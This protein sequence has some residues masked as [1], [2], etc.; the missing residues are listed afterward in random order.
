MP[1]ISFSGLASGIDTD[2]IIE[3]MKEQKRLAYAP[4]QKQLEGKEIENNA[5][6]E[7]NTKL[8]GVNDILKNLLTLGGST[9]A[10]K[11]SVSNEQALSATAGS[12]AAA[13]TT[14][15]NILNIAK[16]ATISFSDTFSSLTEPI[17]PD[18]SSSEN[19][20]IKL[21]TGDNEETF[22][23]EVNNQTTLNDLINEVNNLSGGT[24][25]RASVIN[26]GLEN[27]P[28]YKLIFSSVKTG[29]SSGS[30][31]VTVPSELQSRGVLQVGNIAQAEDAQVSIAGIGTI[32]RSSNQISDVIPGVTLDLKQSGNGPVSIL[33]ANDD[34]KTAKNVNDL[35][36]A[37]N[38]IIKYSND[39][40]KIE[41]IKDS[42]GTTNKYGTLSR[43]DVDNRAVQ[44]IKNA[45]AEA[46]SGVDGSKVR[47]FADL[48]I[49]TQ[50]D[51]TLAFDLEKFQTA[52]TE[53]PNAV[54]NLLHQFADA[55]A[56]SNGGVVNEYTKFQGILDQS[57]ANNENN[58]NQLNDKIA[59][60]EASIA[61]QEEMLKKMFTNL[62]TKISKLNVN[63]QAISSLFNAPTG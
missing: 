39:N 18:L 36:T 25:V 34:D 35:V 44:A 45:L 8:L 1:A 29:V 26:V 43:T 32:N 23:V 40:S 58:I 52:V 42:Q 33:V 47:I 7:F 3:A 50:R 54:D 20:E 49:T 55:T 61:K 5:I 16:S 10:K 62:E 22:N 63:G 2:K 17:A 24:K 14:T 28:E 6:E 11:V 19:L 48:G 53:D 9:F 56:S 59:R 46:N 57:Q 37:V 27:S 4:I 21:G 31:S 12:G 60:L 15:I 41:R 51:G 38:E 13:T 30:L